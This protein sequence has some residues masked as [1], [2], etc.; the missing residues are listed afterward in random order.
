MLFRSPDAERAPSTEEF[1]TRPT[2]VEGDHSTGEGCSSLW[3]KTLS[4]LRGVRFEG[5]KDRKR[6]RSSSSS[7]VSGAGENPDS[8]LAWLLR[9]PPLLRLRAS[10]PRR[11]IFLLPLLTILASPAFLSL[12]LLFSVGDIGSIHH[13]RSRCLYFK[14]AIRD[15][16]G[17]VRVPL[18]VRAWGKAGHPPRSRFR[19][20]RDLRRRILPRRGPLVSFWR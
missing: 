9:T 6:R 15:F 3:A 1:I 2:I 14:F 20:C 12:S 16:A 11:E 10:A 4:K 13:E 18:R 8:Q 19:R 17:A 5:L 7:L